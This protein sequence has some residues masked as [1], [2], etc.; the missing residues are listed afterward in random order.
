MAVTI[1]MMAL[2][3]IAIDDIWSRNRYAENTPNPFNRDVLTVS[4]G[5]PRLNPPILGV[6]QHQE[7]SP[8]WPFPD[9]ESFDRLQDLLV[10]KMCRKPRLRTVFPCLKVEVAVFA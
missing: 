8:G 10:K 5:P 4:L 6:A 9:F 2:I 3:A 7:P 1:M